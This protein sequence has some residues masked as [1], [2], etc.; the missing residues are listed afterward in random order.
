[1]SWLVFLMTALVAFG[2][3]RLSITLSFRIGALDVPN[4]RSSHSQPMP[5][6]GGLGV[7]GAVAI[8]VGV[9]AVTQAAGLINYPLFTRQTIVVLGAGLGMAVTGL[10]DDLYQ[11]RARVKFLMQ[12]VLACLVVGFGYRIE[13]VEVAGGSPLALGLL[14]LPVSVLWLV[15]FCNLYN[16][17]DG[18][19]GISTLT[20]AVYFVFFSV[21][22]WSV[23][24]PELAG[25][26][27]V[28]A[29][30]CVGSLPL[31]FPFARTFMGDTGSLFLGMTLGIYVILFAQRSPALL[32]PSVLVCSAYLWDTGFTLV[33]RLVRGENI[34]AAHRTHLY[35]RLVQLGH[36]HA[37]ITVLYLILH[38]ITGSLALAY[39]SSG[40]AARLAILGLVVLILTAYTLSVY[41]LEA[42]AARVRDH[43]AEGA[44]GSRV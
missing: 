19:D 7:V 42:R 10:C 24:A 31:N 11:L 13:V 23:S 27:M 3:T 20:A 33:R 12:F 37:R 22:A 30:S 4:A 44:A 1:M 2:L 41:W 18:I 36:S 26:A 32:I 39:Y 14:A 6:L 9:L 17:M 8:V 16:F 25:L 34:F 15:A 21:F 29:G 5:R 38:L 28:F 43:Q 40:N 35:Q